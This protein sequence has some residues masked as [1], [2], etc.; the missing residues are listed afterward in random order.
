[1]ETKLEE[2]ERID[3]IGFGNLRLIQ[4]TEDFCYGI[5]AVLLSHFTATNGEQENKKRMK[6]KRSMDLGTGTGIIPLILSHKTDIEEMFGLELQYESFMC[7]IKNIQIN[8][9]EKRINILQGEV[10]EIEK[11]FSKDLL[12]TFDLV[13][14]NPPYM[15]YNSAIKN[16]NK[17]K[18]AA[19]HETSG[20]LDDFIRSAALLLKQKGDFY[21][22]HRPSRLV[23]IFV[24]C[25]ANKLEPKGIQ[26]VSPR[27][28]E[29]PNIL[30]LHCVKNGNAELK[31]MKNLYIYE[32][33]E[34]T[35]EI[36]GIY[37]R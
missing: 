21:M 13:T 3:N 6:V 10:S 1:L 30:L 33:L 27:E 12:G 34:Y 32:G 20:S 11:I 31:L 4:K 15:S 8:E 9:I 35:K 18:L 36:N 14:T 5:D 22:V 26:F 28:G 2:G 7:A 16:E 29:V 23:D 37:E 24:S 19:R 17:A 25:R